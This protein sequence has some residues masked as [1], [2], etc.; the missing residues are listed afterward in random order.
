MYKK[1]KLRVLLL[2]MVLIAYSL[3]P[4]SI[5]YGASSNVTVE[6][7]VNP[8]SIFV[9]EEAEI[10]LSVKGT[11]PANFIVPN[12][13]ILIIDKS[14]SMKP[15]YAPN[16]GEDKIANAKDAAKGFIDLMDMTKHRVGVVDF[17]AD[18]T[19]NSF[20]LT[21]DA[22]SAKT[23]IDGINAN[24]GTATGHAIETA[25]EL[26]NSKRDEA[27]PVIVLLTDGR[28][29]M[30]KNGPISAYE[31][32]KQKAELAKNEQIV[33]YTIALLNVGEN[34]N[35]SDPNLL[36]KEMA[37]TAQHHHFVLGSIGLA[38]IYNKIV[39][40]I[41]IAS[42][43]NVTLSD[44]VAS[45]FEIVPDSYKDNIPQ[46]LIEGNKLIWEFQELKDEELTFKYKIRHKEG[47]KSWR[48]THINRFK[49]HIFGL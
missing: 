25:M 42:A 11:P 12:D 49:H 33:F 27:Q 41:G 5:S 19:T 45:E 13:V 23:Y 34:P 47:E 40:E 43:Y 15:D 31:Y 2:S 32:A 1:N 48:V 20:A 30:P 3:T 18:T 4:F 29:T 28:A 7:T 16:N 17:S 14:G 22:E 9:D 44:I 35:V 38:E 46:P 26:L 39:Q 8:D 21:A 37:T 10:T 6:K 36:L 24:G